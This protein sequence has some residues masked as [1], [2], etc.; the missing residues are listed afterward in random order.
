MR[1]GEPR[2]LWGCMGNCVMAA[3]LALVLLVVL[4]WPIA[5]FT[6]NWTRRGMDPVFLLWSAAISFAISFIVVALVRRAVEE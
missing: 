3:M 6:G 2:L 5:I 4:G 1:Y